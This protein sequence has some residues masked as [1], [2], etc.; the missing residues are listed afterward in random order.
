MF[1][2]LALTASKRYT[3]WNAAMRSAAFPIASPY[4]V[5]SVPIPSST[6]NR[7]FTRVGAP[8][9]FMPL[10]KDF[11]LPSSAGYLANSVK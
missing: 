1:L 2:C 8:F 3:E 11:D 4:S 6:R 9:T 5:N 10:T 7:I